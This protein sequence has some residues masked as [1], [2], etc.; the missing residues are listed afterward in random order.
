M[1][2]S[3]FLLNHQ[4]PDIKTFYSVIAALSYK[5]RVFA[6]SIHFHPNLI[7]EGKAG[8]YQYGGPYGTLP[9]RFRHG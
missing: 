3:G 5:A 6:T 4:R 9:T 2:L 1:K 8:A 7:F